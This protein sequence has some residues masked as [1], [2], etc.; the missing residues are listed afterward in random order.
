[1]I[2]QILCLI[3][4]LLLIVNLTYASESDLKPI[5]LRSYFTFPPEGVSGNTAGQ[6]EEEINSVLEKHQ[7]KTVTNL[8]RQREIKAY[9]DY[10]QQAIKETFKSLSVDNIIIPTLTVKDDGLINSSL[11][12]YDQQL[13]ALYKKVS[14][15][16]KGRYSNIRSISKWLDDYFTNLPPVGKISSYNYALNKYSVDIQFP[17]MISLASYKGR[18]FNIYCISKLCSNEDKKERTGVFYQ[19]DGKVIKGFIYNNPFSENQKFF[20]DR[21]IVIP[22]NKAPTKIEKNIEISSKNIE[23]S[24]NYAHSLRGCF[25]LPFIGNVKDIEQI[26]EDFIRKIERDGRCI[27]RVDPQIMQILEKYQTNLP[28]YLSKNKIIKLI[29]HKSS[30]GSIFRIKINEHKMGVIV[31]FEVIGQNG[32]DIYF[33]RRKILNEYDPGF[34]NNL[35]Y[36]W[37]LK[38]VKNL[39]L[40]ASVIESVEQNV[41]FD[42]GIRAVHRN[43]QNFEIIRPEK[44]TIAKHG[45]K[46]DTK[47]QGRV[48]AQGVVREIHNKNSLGYILTTVDASTSIRAGDWVRL[49]GY[50]KLAD[51]K[52]I[53]MK[54]N[55]K[56]QRHRFRLNAGFDVSKLSGSSTNDKTIASLYLGADIFFP[57]GLLGYLESERD[58]SNL[59]DF[60]LSRN[61]FKAA[62]GYSTII[63]GNL[64]VSLFDIHIGYMNSYLETSALAINGL[65]D[66]SYEG[67]YASIRFEAP[68]YK[69]STI[70][71]GVYGSPLLEI[72][73][74]HDPVLFSSTLKS[75]MFGTFFSADYRFR[76]DMTF[77]GQ[78]LYEKYITEMDQVL[79]QP[80]DVVDINITNTKFRVGIHWNF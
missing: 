57:Y 51:I 47:W 36:Q 37:M 41:L 62:L 63:D 50:D 53:F 40:D 73:N 68:I 24:P 32:M 80:G 34:I 79:G 46:S 27:N 15:N 64:L 70:Y 74:N 65:G 1:M 39:P 21:W 7:I 16:N 19:V 9:K 69:D 22:S 55:I 43:D 28:F 35:L 54:H 52:P 20:D 11:T 72:T 44:I 76:Y 61:N 45:D 59:G 78:V 75:K 71:F 23:N 42:L 38:Y 31:S 12:I 30:S 33:S 17:K 58:L 25:T 26:R 77:F 29:A 5:Q 66:L 8:R 13:N 14:Q 60:S 3:T 48:I 18:E 10:S 56:N 4:T 67:P 2:T 49:I 6:L